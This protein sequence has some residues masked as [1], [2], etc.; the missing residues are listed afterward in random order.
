MR[1]IFLLLARVL[2]V[3]NYFFI[4]TLRNLLM[5]RR[6]KVNNLITLLPN[7]SNQYYQLILLFGERG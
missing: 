1:L 5:R 6:D 4:I 2:S 7:A 3:L